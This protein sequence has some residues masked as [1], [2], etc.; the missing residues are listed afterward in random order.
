[1]CHDGF[2]LPATMHKPL[3]LFPLQQTLAHNE[4]LKP[5][6]C[7]SDSN[8]SQSTP[9]SRA[10]QDSG[11]ANWIQDVVVESLSIMR[12]IPASAVFLMMMKIHDI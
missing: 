9:G 7:T 11:H 12:V 5:P 6:C 8:S 4:G 3:Y 10:S 1:M 2:T